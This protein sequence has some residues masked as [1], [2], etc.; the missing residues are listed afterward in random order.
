MKNALAATRAALTWLVLTASLVTAGLI[1]RRPRRAPPTRPTPLSHQRERP[2]RPA[3][4]ARRSSAQLAKGD[5]VL[6][7]GSVPGPTGCPSPTPTPPATSGPTYLDRR[8]E[9]R[10]R[11]HHRTG[12]QEGRHRNVNVR[13]SRQPRRRH[14][15]RRSRRGTSVKVTGVTSGTFTQVTVRHQAPVDL[16]RVPLHG[17]RHHPRRGRHL[18]HHRRPRPA[19]APASVTATN[20]GTIAKGAN[21]RRHRHPLRQLQ[22]GRLHRQGRL[23]HHRLPQGRR[24]HPDR[25]RPARSARTPGTPPS[26]TSSSAPRTPTPPPTRSRPSPQRKRVRTTGTVKGD[27]TQVIWDGATGWVATISLSSPSPA[28]TVRRPRLGQPEQARALRQGRRASRSAQHFPEIK[29]IYGWR[30]SSAYSSDHPNGRA[31]DN[32]IPDYKTNKALGDAVAAWVDRQR[33]AP[34]HHLPDLAAAAATRISRG[35]WKKMADRGSDTANH[36]NHVHISFEPS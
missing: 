33:Q 3:A 17:H 1:V 32:M 30:A 18:H 24:R 26:T 16:L 2:L 12:R 19:R 36:M 34:A 4:P 14:H 11:R 23:G 7:A 31:T 15:R 25:P 28:R 13:A 27:F 21:G 8:H 10:H 5:H 29:T 9:G 35:S 22:P 6:A 20:Q